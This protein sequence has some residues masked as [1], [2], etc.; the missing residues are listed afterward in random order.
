MV[1]L[2]HRRFRLFLSLAVLFTTGAFAESN[3]ERNNDPERS[4]KN[5]FHLLASPRIFSKSDFGTGDK[6]S[7]PGIP[8]ISMQAGFLRQK[9]H[10]EPMVGLSILRRDSN[11][12]S[13]S[14]TSTSESS[15]FLVT[16]MIG[17]RQNGWSPYWFPIVPYL[18]AYLTYGVVFFRSEIKDSSSGSVVKT[19]T[20]YNGGEIGA[21]LGGGFQTSLA[22]MNRSLE[23]ELNNVWNLS[24]YGL[25]FHAH[26]YPG[27]IQRS[28]NFKSLDTL[29]SMSLGGGLYVAW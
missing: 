24:D 25:E 5:S 21:Q 2:R 4:L 7:S 6:F 19:K 3:L 15:L 18:E 20:D 10:L 17:A 29:K 12:T 9:F 26:Y 11:T 1:Y 16:A 8:E 27:K 13:L 28:G 23:S 22:A 14:A